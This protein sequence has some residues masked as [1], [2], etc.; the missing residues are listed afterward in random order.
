MKVISAVSWNIGYC[1]FGHCDGFFRNSGEDRN[2]CTMK[3]E[4]CLVHVSQQL[5][6][7][8]LQS[9]RHRDFLRCICTIT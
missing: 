9:R 6:I 2:V 1:D 3:N 7:H 5:N 4:A 8:Q